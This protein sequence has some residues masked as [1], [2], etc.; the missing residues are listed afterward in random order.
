MRAFAERITADDAVVRMYRRMLGHWVS[1][2]LQGR[3]VVRWREPD[4]TGDYR[5]RDWHRLYSGSVLDD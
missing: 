3:P 2:L 5:N 4:L 1:D